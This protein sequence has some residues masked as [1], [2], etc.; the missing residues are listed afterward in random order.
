MSIKIGIISD[1]HATPGPVEEALS[2]FRQQNVQ[3]VL[4]AGDIAGYGEALDETVELLIA[5]NCISIMGNHDEWYLEQNKNGDSSISYRYLE[6][7]PLYQ[8]M[9]IEDKKLYMVHASPPYSS[10]NGIK[11]Y[12]VYG[13]LMDKKLGDWNNRLESFTKDILVVGHTHQFFAEQ[14]GN[15][16]VINPGSTLFNHSCALLILPELQVKWF[17]L[18]G[19][20]LKRTW[21]WAANPGPLT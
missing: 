7:L 5:N 6:N 15:T 21:N 1:I 2:I 20:A 13:E 8:H 14:L 11:L 10:M 4:C 12:D 18:S 19:E 17:A 3:H 9:N 16:L